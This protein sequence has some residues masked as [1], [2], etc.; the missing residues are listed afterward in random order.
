MSTPDVIACVVMGL[1]GM[2]AAFLILW[3]PPRD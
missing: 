2:L 3:T 1:L